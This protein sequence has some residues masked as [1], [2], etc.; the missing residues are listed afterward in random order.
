MDRSQMT[1]MSSMS[2]NTHDTH[3]HQEE[4]VVADTITTDTITTDIITTDTTHDTHE[5]QENM[6]M[7]AMSGMRMGSMDRAQMADMSSMSGTSGEHMRGV[8]DN[9]GQY[10]DAFEMHASDVNNDNVINI[11]D[12]YSVL[13]GD[14]T[15]LIMIDNGHIDMSSS[16]M[17]DYTVTSDLV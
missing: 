7:E 8:L 11:M 17:E 13:L 4:V 5:H 3:E 14:T 15:N 10:V 1:D 9:I 16:F 12:M 2:G 6:D